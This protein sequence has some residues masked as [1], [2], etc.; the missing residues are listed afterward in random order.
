[1]TIPRGQNILLPAQLETDGKGIVQDLLAAFK[2]INKN[3]ESE[4]VF[5]VFLV[6]TLTVLA[7]H[8]PV[9]REKV[10]DALL[11]KGEALKSTTDRYVLF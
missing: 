4:E 7:L 11:E 3:R 5:R 2:E 9:V 8:R 10:M 6:N 1:M